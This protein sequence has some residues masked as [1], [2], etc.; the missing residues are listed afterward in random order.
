MYWKVHSRNQRSICAFLLLQRR[1]L[2]KNHIPLGS[3]S[4]SFQWTIFRPINMASSHHQECVLQA[5]NTQS[6]IP[7]TH[8]HTQPLPPP[9]RP[10]HAHTASACSFLLIRCH[11]LTC[12]R[13]SLLFF[14][15]TVSVFG[16]CVV[17]V[18][19]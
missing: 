2:F 17:P 8:T 14:L 12:S 5:V 1:D 18:Q 10:Q 3:S 4:S 19:P 11:L 15:R 7:N 16:S 13:T 9:P 6:P